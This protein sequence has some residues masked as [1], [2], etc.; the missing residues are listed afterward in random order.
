M[1]PARP[2]ITSMPPA[3]VPEDILQHLQ[4]VKTNF[5]HLTLE[6]TIDSTWSAIKADKNLSSKGKKSVIKMAR[7][8]L[9][10]QLHAK[11]LLKRKPDAHFPKARHTKKIKNWMDSDA[12][13]KPPKILNRKLNYQHLLKMEKAPRSLPNLIH[14]WDPSLIQGIDLLTTRNTCVNVLKEML[15]LTEAFGMYFVLDPIDG[16]V[17]SCV[18]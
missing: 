8:Q 13:T 1:P 15:M 11:Q 17:A 14:A 3:F 5:P 18:H 12:T 7:E 6:N 9:D 10:K 4:A 16:N 2:V